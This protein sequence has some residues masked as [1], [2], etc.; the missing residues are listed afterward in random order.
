MPASQPASASKS[1]ASHCKHER[2][3]GLI[4]DLDERPG[5]VARA[6][7]IAKSGKVASIAAL[8]L[9]LTADGYLNST[10]TL[11]G[12]AVSTQLSRIIAERRAE[13]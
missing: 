12:R 9:Q 8:Q 10:E 6:F 2:K 13:A 3:R 4:I 1:I 11:S 7:Q 5:I